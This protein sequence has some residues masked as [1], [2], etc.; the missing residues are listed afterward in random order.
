MADICSLLIS[1]KQK[2]GAGK[3]C[4]VQQPFITEIDIE[5]WK[6][7]A[8]YN[9]TIDYLAKDKNVEALL[10]SLEYGIEIPKKRAIAAANEIA[11]SCYDDAFGTF[12][13]IA[14]EIRTRSMEL[15]S[16]EPLGAQELVLS[17][18]L[19]SAVLTTYRKYGLI[20]DAEKLESRIK[21]MNTFCMK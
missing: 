10:L 3:T 20:A 16:N 14:R 5:T 19:E 7:N 9:S 15:V 11:K 18:K 12:M 1:Q 8:K 17:H 4:V 21:S 6:G 2:S 13:D